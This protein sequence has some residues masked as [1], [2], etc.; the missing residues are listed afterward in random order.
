MYREVHSFVCLF[1][2]VFPGGK[3]EG[4]VTGVPVMCPPN[5][6]T[7]VEHHGKVNPPSVVQEV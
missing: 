2:I 4:H 7:A 3:G 5:M 1:K 6:L